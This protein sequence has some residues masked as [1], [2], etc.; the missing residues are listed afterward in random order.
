[1][2]DAGKVGGAMDT[3]KS[4]RALK[5]SR[6]CAALAR[7]VSDTKIACVGEWSIQARG[8]WT[9]ICADP[10]GH[11]LDSE[12]VEAIGRGDRQWH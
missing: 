12:R 2:E 4:F 9:K 6:R 1:M 5:A 7:H 3:D 10:E 8:T 11:C